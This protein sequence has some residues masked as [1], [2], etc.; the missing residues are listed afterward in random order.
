MIQFDDIDDLFREAAGSYELTPRETAWRRLRRQLLWRKLKLAIGLGV[1]MLSLLLV[2]ILALPGDDGASA[3][4]TKNLLTPE[5]VE[6]VAANS[7]LDQ[8][9]AADNNGGDVVAAA[10]VGQQ[11]EKHSPG[12][13]SSDQGFVAADQ[14]RVNES[15]SFGSRKVSLITPLRLLE[16][17]I[18]M[19]LQSGKAPAK[20]TLPEV[21]PPTGDSVDSASHRSLGFEGYTGLA[22]SQFSGFEAGTTGHLELRDQGSWLLAPSVGTGLRYQKGNWYVA[23]GIAW[24]RIGQKVDFNLTTN[25]LDNQLSYWKYDTTWI[26]IYDP[27]FYGEPWPASVDSSFV[28]VFKKQS[29]SGVLA[30]DYLSIP[31]MVGYR[32]REGGVSVGAGFG[33]QLS[34]PVGYQ[35]KAPNAALSQLLEAKA[36][37]SHQMD[38]GF[39]VEMEGAALFH[40]RYWFFFRPNATFGVSNHT[41][42][43]SGLK[44]RNHSLGVDVGIRIDFNP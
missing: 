26:Y 9:I 19:V 31:L 38:V 5:V 4:A 13:V 18:E 41:G 12:G 29:Y 32:L 3:V 43:E 40:R 20:R 10:S 1:A 23:A 44:Y 34:L 2:F 35:G 7:Q 14:A 11:S 22:F 42:G 37:M 36:E 21:L 24:K 33:L 25:D 16:T 6:Q 15:P 17:R 30:V 28:A 39:R 27:P 8:S